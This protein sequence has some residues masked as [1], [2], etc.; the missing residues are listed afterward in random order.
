MNNDSLLINNETLSI[1]VP[2]SATMDWAYV[3]PHVITG[4]D[5]HIQPILGSKLL[6][7]LF[8][9][10][11]GGTIN[12]VANATYKSLL[13]DY[14]AKTLAHWTMYEAI[15]FLPV[16]IVNSSIIRPELEEGSSIELDESMSL[17]ENE[18]SI[19]EFYSERLYAYLEESDIAEYEMADTDDLVG[20][21]EKGATF[22]L[23]LED[24]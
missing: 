22:G 24:Y 8:D 12:D 21:T 2:I 11:S 3:R 16:K 19:A 20:G 15:P 4:Q 14:V 1:Y 13:T 10:V 23:S 18:K 17:R 7:K 9:L 6:Q 5:K